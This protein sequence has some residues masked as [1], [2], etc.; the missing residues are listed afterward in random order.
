MSIILSGSGLRTGNS[1]VKVLEFG[2]EG[3]MTLNGDLNTT[4][5]AGFTT[6]TATG[7]AS[8]DGG[9]NVNDNVTVSAA[10]AIAGA[11]TID[12]SGD[13]TVGTITM[14]EFTVDGSGNTDIDGTLNVE[15]VPTFQAGAVF[16]GGVTTANAI[17]GATT[18]SGSGK[19]SAGGGI[20]AGLGAEFTV[21]NAG[22]VVAASLNNSSGGITNAGSIAGAT[23]INASGVVTAG[24]L[25]VGSAVLSEADLEQLDDL[26]A[27]TA[28]ASKALVV[29]S[30]KDIGTIRHLTSNGTLTGAS[31]SFGAG[32]FT[33]VAASAAITAGTSFI[34]GSADLNETDLEKLD[35]ITNGTVAA[36]KAVVVDGSKDADGIN[37]LTLEGSLII[38]NASMNE[39]DLEKLDGIT[40]GTAAAN[41]ALVL[42]SD[43]DIGT[44]RNLT[45][46]GSVSS[47]YLTA[48]HAYIQNLDVGVINSKTT[49]VENVEVS[50]SL[51]ILS[52]GSA[53][54]NEADGSGLFL[55][56]ANASLLWDDG[57]SRMNLNK[58]LNVAG[59]LDSSG[60]LTVASIT[61]SEF[62]V[63]SSGNTDVDGT[64]N[65]EGVP[66]F[67]A[68]AVFSGGVTTANAIA[69]ATTVSGSGKFSAG[70]GID[71]GL[72]AQFTV[73]NAGAV[74]AASLNNSSG[75]ITNA[76]AIAGATT[77]DASG[78]LTVGTITMAE[79]TVDGSGNTDIDGTLN[80]EG[81]PTFQRESVH[82][83]GATFNSA[84]LAAC[85]A[86]AGA[87]TI[88]GSGLLSMSHIDLD[89]DLDVNGTANL[90]AVDIDGAVQLD[91]TLTVGVNDTG[92]DVKFY[93]ATA[94]SY[95]MWDESSNSLNMINSHM[96]GA[97]ATFHGAVYSMDD[98]ANNISILVP[99][100]HSVKAGQFVTFSDATLKKNV[101]QLDGAIEKVMSMRGVSYEMK[102]DNRGRAEVGFIAQEMKQVVPEVVYGDKDGNHGI[103]Y[104]KLTSIL[105]EA[106]KAQQTQIDELKALLKK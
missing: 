29:D 99:E 44:I 30:N 36:N 13:L 66:T 42:D 64:L 63:D 52:S 102:K 76:G 39:T 103:D 105:V 51:M 24:G 37:D 21:S 69:G 50:A 34:I 19:F 6:I 11:T 67:Q 86:I 8:L 28:T 55:S 60:D 97:S 77:I 91:N 16:S 22:A 90:D 62:T 59:N 61:M 81:V 32:G 1:T 80:V 23:T 94:G 88:S 96:S 2:T 54:S 14:S 93:G 7:L 49:T 58:P 35:G 31:A 106:V 82:S 85:G 26:S 57:N 4:G 20:D 73:S 98:A 89:G 45:S 27:G 12:A 43:K 92:Y 15:G 56:G 5:S 9:I 83:A 95:L 38:G 65:V 41:K 46:N 87:T 40:D 53:T 70:G 25:T 48:S 17:A 3:T 18:V 100:T 33:T 101:K 47:V 79:F 10:G 71:A 84:G 104:G 75:G 74:V 68:G 78:D 72:G